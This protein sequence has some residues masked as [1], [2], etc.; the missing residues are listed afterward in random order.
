LII[1]EKIKDARKKAKLSQKEL[2][3]KLGV[4]Q[5]MIA[6]YESGK[7]IPKLGTLQKLANALDVPIGEL[8]F[9]ASM[10]DE[11]APEFITPT[12]NLDFL[13]KQR[14]T[15]ETTDNNFMKLS[16]A[17]CLLNNKGRDKAIEQVELLTKIPEYQK[18]N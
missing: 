16:E 9:Y 4:S 6:Q 1:G 2:G 7:R 8:M 18:E 12:N 14:H 3:M 13:K 17:Y 15:I 5:A 11:K 10:I